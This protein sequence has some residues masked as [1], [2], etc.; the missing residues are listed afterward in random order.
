MNIE[1]LHNGDTKDFYNVKNLKEDDDWI[2]FD[3]VLVD[4]IF[5]FITSIFGS[6]K[7]Y[8]IKGEITV[9]VD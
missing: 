6:R 1:V 9:Y 4:E 7:H 8:K 2:E 3:G 5:P